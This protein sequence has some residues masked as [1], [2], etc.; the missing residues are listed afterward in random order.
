[1]NNYVLKSKV[2]R[3]GNNLL[4]ISNAIAIAKKHQG[5]FLLT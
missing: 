4:Q 1:M 2:G 3:F 5:K